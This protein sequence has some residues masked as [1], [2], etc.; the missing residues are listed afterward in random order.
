MIKHRKFCPIDDSLDIELDLVE[1]IVDQCSRLLPIRRLLNVELHTVN[2][3]IDFSACKSIVIWNILFL[4][5]YPVTPLHT[6]SLCLVAT[7]LGAAS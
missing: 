2:D 1:T 3:N 6:S 7:P 4:F 5:V